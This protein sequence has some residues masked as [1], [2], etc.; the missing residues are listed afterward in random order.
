MKT[1]RPLICAF[2]AIPGLMFLCAGSVGCSG[3]SLDAGIKSLFEGARSPQQNLLIAVSSDDPDL[4]RD[5]LTKIARSRE[6]RSEW[7]VKAYIAMATLETDPQTRCIAVRALTRSN[8]ARAPETL[9]K[10]L[11]FRAYPASEV[12]P[13]ADDVRADSARGLADLLTADMVAL[14][15][16]PQIRDVL[17]DRLKNDTYRHTRLFA[18]RGLGNYPERL[19]V[20]ALV[21]ALRDDD[22]AVA[23]ESETSMAKLTGQAFHCSVLD[24]EAWTK[25]NPDHLFDGKGTVPPAR[26]PAYQGGWDKFGYDMNQVYRYFY[27]EEKER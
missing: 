21:L 20:D 9:L 1:A 18:A 23:R 6:S 13:P 10:I 22:F 12:Y 26:K 15:L 8:D 17:I 14:E 24:W 27:P 5:A 16:R 2:I 19:V 3:S 25:A 7:A 4:R 11:N